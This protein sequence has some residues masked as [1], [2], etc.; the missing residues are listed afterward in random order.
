SSAYQL[1]LAIIQERFGLASWNVYPFHFSD[2]DNWGDSDN[3]RCLE[4]V[5]ELLQRGNL[6]GYG[7]IQQSGRRSQS[8][9]MSTFARLQDP[10]FVG[11]TIGGKQDVYPALRAFFAPRGA[12]PV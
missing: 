12:L 6:F 7:E 1:A 3:Q 9:L 5:R 8:T 2:G 10:R 11:V 4:L